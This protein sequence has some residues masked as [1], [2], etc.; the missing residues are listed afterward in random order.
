[1]ASTTTTPSSDGF[2]RPSAARKKQPTRKAAPRYY[3]FPPLLTGPVGFSKP[4]V[5]LLK[6][7]L[8]E[9]TKPLSLTPAELKTTA[10]KKKTA[11]KDSSVFVFTAGQEPGAKTMGSPDRRI[12]GL[13]NDSDLECDCGCDLKALFPKMERSLISDQEELDGSV[14]FKAAPQKIESSVGE[15]GTAGSA[16]QSLLD[17]LMEGALGDS[18]EKTDAGYESLP[19]RVFV[20][21]GCYLFF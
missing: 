14:L 11:V 3:S 17:D 19:V 16:N 20:L 9:F 18:T 4:P 21:S 13:D 8:A 12:D 1:M 7:G 10:G 5:P 2:S 6:E 15:P